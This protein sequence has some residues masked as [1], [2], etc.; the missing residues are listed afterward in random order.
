MNII[1]HRGV[2]N[3]TTVI[4]NTIPAFKI[5]KDLK[6]AIELD[7]NITKDK[8]VVVF[9]DNNL[10]RFFNIKK[11]IN[12]LTYK[13]LSKLRFKNRSKI[14]T[15]K[16]V[17]KLINGDVPLY[18]EIK[19]SKYYM[20][21]C[22]KVLSLLKEYKG[23]VYIQSFNKKIVKYFLNNGY[24][25]GLIITNNI[26]SKWYRNNIMLYYTLLKLK[27]SFLTISK[28]RKLCKYM[29]KYRILLWTFHG[30]KET[31]K[32]NQKFYFVCDNLL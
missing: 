30:I 31:D 11:N 10:K 18:I 8:E 3:N 25:S 13:D 26:E 29:L 20:D 15:L 4:E 21:T 16:E 27:P 5:A 9:H 2:Y 1:A 22:D 6:L 19:D 28:D 32:Y 24:L 12:D 17:L 23:L 7:V 14:P